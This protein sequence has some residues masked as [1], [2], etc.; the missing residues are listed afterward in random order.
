LAE[1]VLLK[2]SLKMVLQKAMVCLQLQLV[3]LASSLMPW[4]VLDS[5]MALCSAL[6]MDHL[7][8]LCS[9]LKMANLMEY[10]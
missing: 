3:A 9:A 4:L 10:C 7:K 1:K 2:A 6:Q 8:A 5:L